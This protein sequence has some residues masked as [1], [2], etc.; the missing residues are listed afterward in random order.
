[1]YAC[2]LWSKY[3]QA[4]ITS[5]KRLNAT[6]NNA[7]WVMC[8][9][10]KNAGVCPHQVNYCVR[11]FDTLLPWWET[12]C[13]DFLYNAHH[14]TFLFNCFKCH[15][16]S[17]IQSSCVIE[18]NCSSCWCIVVSVFASHQYCFCVV[19]RK[20]CVYDVMYTNQVCQK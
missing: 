2:Q 15:V 6:Y 3:T 4:S 13:I 17:I 14:L 20:K 7:Y 18:T 10:P 11:T 19:K 12:V 1:M 8:L 5:M 16:S 9:I